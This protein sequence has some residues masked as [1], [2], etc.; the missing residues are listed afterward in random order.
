MT[1][2]EKF[3]YYCRLYSQLTQEE[4]GFIAAQWDYDNGLECW[5]D[6]LIKKKEMPRKTR[7]RNTYITIFIIAF[8]LFIYWFYNDYRIAKK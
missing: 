4:K 8:L 2:E 5:Q 7:I 3:N 1:D 6:R